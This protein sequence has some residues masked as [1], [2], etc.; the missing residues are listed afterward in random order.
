MPKLDPGAKHGRRQIERLPIIRRRLVPFVPVAVDVCLFQERF[1]SGFRVSPPPQPC[2]NQRPKHH[3]LTPSQTN[4]NR[5][6]VPPMT[7]P[8]NARP[9]HVERFTQ[10]P[11]PHH[12]YICCQAKTGKPAFARQSKDLPATIL[13]SRHP[14]QTLCG[15]PADHPPSAH[16]SSPSKSPHGSGQAGYIARSPQ[17]HSQSS[18]PP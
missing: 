11:L 3:R 16:P 10:G 13:S 7:Q 14:Q 15:W 4:R 6:S 17:L 5:A 2:R 9:T 8:D 1:S 18:P 12:N